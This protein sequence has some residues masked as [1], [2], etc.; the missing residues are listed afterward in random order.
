MFATL[1]EQMKHD[2][3]LASTPAERTFKWSAVAVGSVVLFA[4]LYYAIQL[5]A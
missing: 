4:A 2:E 3:Q 1:D 5:F